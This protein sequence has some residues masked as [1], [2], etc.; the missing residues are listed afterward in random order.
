MSS[1]GY[2]FVASLRREIERTNGFPVVFRLSVRKE[3]VSFR[4]LFIPVSNVSTPL[5]TDFPLRKNLH[6]VVPLF[7]PP[8]LQHEYDPSSYPP[9]TISY[10]TQHIIGK[11]IFKTFS[12]NSLLTKRAPLRRRLRSKIFS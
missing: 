11:N 7:G 12:N 3:P 1:R 8:S 5:K 6:L 2:F 4:R 10:S 9:S